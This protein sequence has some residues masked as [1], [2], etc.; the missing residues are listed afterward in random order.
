M[1]EAANHSLFHRDRRTVHE[2][3]P[4]RQGA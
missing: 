1:S 4:G 2:P 3:D